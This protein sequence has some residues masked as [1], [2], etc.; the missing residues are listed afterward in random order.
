MPFITQIMLPKRDNLD[1]LFNAGDPLKAGFDMFTGALLPT[2]E[3]A[4]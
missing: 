2:L 3:L 4:P 1:V